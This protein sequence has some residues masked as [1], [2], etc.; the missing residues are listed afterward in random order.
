MAANFTRSRLLRT[1]CDFI[2]ATATSTHSRYRY[3][4]S[5]VEAVSA[6]FCYL[7]ISSK[8][9]LFPDVRYLKDSDFLRTRSHHPRSFLH[10]PLDS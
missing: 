10:R 2:L 7:A 9:L 3:K 4:P 8:F 6:A 5:E 1:F